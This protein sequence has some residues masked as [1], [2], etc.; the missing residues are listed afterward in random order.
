MGYHRATFDEVHR[1][2]Q[3]GGVGALVA[4]RRGPRQPHPNRVSAEVE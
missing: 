4:Q 3:V 2:F 1:A